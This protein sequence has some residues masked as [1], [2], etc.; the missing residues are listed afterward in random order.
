MTVKVPTIVP[1]QTRVAVA[2]VPRVT[3]DGM[4]EQLRPAGLTVA[5]KLTLPLPPEPVRVMV[6]VL[7]D[8]VLKL[9]VVGLAVMVKSNG[10]WTAMMN[11]V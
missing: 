6:L 2:V 1:V 5:F 3:V 7:E 9:R 4:T 8:P 11:S 10:A